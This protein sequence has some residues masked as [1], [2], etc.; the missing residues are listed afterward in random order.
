MLDWQHLVVTDS[1]FLV[2]DYEQWASYKY[3]ACVTSGCL[4]CFILLF[5]K[6]LLLLK[7]SFKRKCY[8]FVY[9]YLYEVVWKI[10]GTLFSV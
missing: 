10:I 4:Y 7:W 6:C 8:T 3:L 9:I 2:S 5:N 1:K